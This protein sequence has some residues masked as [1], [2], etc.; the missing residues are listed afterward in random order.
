MIPERRGRPIKGGDTSKHFARFCF[1][2]FFSLRDASLSSIRNGPGVLL[3]LSDPALVTNSSQQEGPTGGHLYD[4]LSCSCYF[5]NSRRVRPTVTP[6]FSSLSLTREHTHTHR[7][8]HYRGTNNQLHFPDQRFP[9][10]AFRST[11][12]NSW[13]SLDWQVAGPNSYLL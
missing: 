7:G 8:A 3:R 6:T 13:F 10:A 1:G 5:E 9:R 4:S 2:F 12:P 11:E